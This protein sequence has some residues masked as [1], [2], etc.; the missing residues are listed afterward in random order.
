MAVRPHKNMVGPLLAARRAD[1]RGGHEWQLSTDGGKTWSAAP[2]TLQGKT[3]LMGFTPGQTV[4][5]RHRPVT[6]DGE[7]AFCEP[8]A[9]IIK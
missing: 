8:I 7:G 5:L 9:L 1:D 3:I 2:R 4:W 6:L